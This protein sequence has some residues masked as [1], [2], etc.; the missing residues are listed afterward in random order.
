MARG[1]ESNS[2]EEQQAESAAGRKPRGPLPSPEQLA[3]QKREEDLKLSRAHVTQQLRRAVNPRHRKVLEDAL[4]D[5]DAKLAGLVQAC[6]R[7]LL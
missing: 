5:L 2:V 1:W 4:A 3:H 6:A 7:F